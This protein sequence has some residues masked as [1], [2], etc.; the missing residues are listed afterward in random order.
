M[1]ISHKKN[2][3]QKKA[4]I[5]KNIFFKQR[6]GIKINKIKFKQLRM[7]WMV[8]SIRFKNILNNINKNKLKKTHKK[9]NKKFNVHEKIVF[10]N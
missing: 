6:C 1:K 8:D 3:I 7:I 2:Y 4:C 10:Y 9:S 5:D